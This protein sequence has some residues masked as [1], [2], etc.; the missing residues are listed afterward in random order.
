V[1]RAKT[2]KPPARKP[3]P[4][5]K[6]AARKP[7]RSASASKPHPRT[8]ST[9]AVEPLQTALAAVRREDHAGAR[10][11]LIAAWRARPSPVIAEL[12]AVLDAK[13]PDALVAQLAAVVTPRVATTLANFKALAGID[14][15]RIA[16][17]AIHALVTLPFSAEGAKPL[18]VA[19]LDHLAMLNDPRLADRAMEVHDA[20]DTRINRLAVRT[21]LI[22]KLCKTIAATPELAADPAAQALEAELATALEPLRCTARSTDALLAEIYANPED[23]APRIVYA[24]L[25]TEQGDPRGEL[26]TLQL[27]RAASGDDQ[28]SEREQ[29]LLKKHGKAWLGRL[30]PVISW[31]KGYA[32]SQFRRGFLAVADII[33]SVN[34][35]L[36]PLLGEPAWATVEQLHGYSDHILVMYA[37]LRA[38]KSLDGLT[39]STLAMAASLGQVLPAL[40]VLDL[41][42]SEEELPVDQVRALA[43]NLT[44]LKSWVREFTPA[45]LERLA[46]Y[47]T[48]ELVLQAWYY[49]APALTARRTAHDLAVAECI[50]MAAPSGVERVTIRPPFSRNDEKTPV[51]LERDPTGRLVQVSG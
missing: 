33:L 19:M 1:A 20:I 23:D 43:P 31:G 41:G 2:K 49:E 4:Q 7:A 39:A 3:S 5:R 11:A 15:P 22:E 9:S 29:E 47:G 44:T 25:L 38:L 40:R 12:V 45:H 36:Y 8:R 24:D 42:H 16:T 30:A 27:A 34:K 21:S 28:P 32:Y 17:Y 14:D 48:R 18:Y 10:E 51:V 6:P 46:R 26:I 35:K 13:S 37:P 50:G